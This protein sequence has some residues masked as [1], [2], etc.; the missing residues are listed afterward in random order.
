M[1]KLIS[2]ILTHEGVATIVTNGF[3]GPHVTA[4]WHSYIIVEE[5][6]EWL[7][8][9]GGY[10]KTEKNIQLGSKVIIMLGSKEVV[11][12]NG[13]GVGFRLTGHADFL[14]EGKL[15]EKINK[16]HP[17]ARAVM[18]FATEKEEQLQ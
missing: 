16:I 10:V 4:T 7:I 15:F 11:Q 1:K 13:L 5:S 17:W 2:E 6:G 8:P 12:K 18:V 9:A 14:S 3:E